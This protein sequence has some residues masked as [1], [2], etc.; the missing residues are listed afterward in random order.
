MAI[1]VSQTAAVGNGGWL[2]AEHHVDAEELQQLL[3][4]MELDRGRA[5]VITPPPLA[6]LEAQP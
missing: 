2:V 5:R 3:R 6:A 1:P 4:D